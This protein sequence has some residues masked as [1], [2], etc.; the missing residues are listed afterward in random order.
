MN[1][2]RILVLG[3]VVLYLPSMPSLAP[4]T[5]LG[6]S[7][8]EQSIKKIEKYLCE[9]YNNKMLDSVDEVRHS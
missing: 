5:L 3:Y 6:N 4:T 1:Y 8:N 2:K 9:I 7:I